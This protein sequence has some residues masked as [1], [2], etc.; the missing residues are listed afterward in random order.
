MELRVES[1][2]C[3]FL[4]EG[5]LGQIHRRTEWTNFRANLTSLEIYGC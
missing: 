5:R 3:E 1:I 2:E 4:F